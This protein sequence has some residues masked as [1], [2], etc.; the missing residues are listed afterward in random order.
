MID[1]LDV[2]KF[3]LLHGRY[4][5][6]EEGIFLLELFEFIFIQL[7]DIDHF[8]LRLLLS[9]GWHLHDA[10]DIRVAIHCHIVI[11]L[12]VIAMDIV[13]VCQKTMVNCLLIYS[14][15]SAAARELN[16]LFKL[17][18]APHHPPLFL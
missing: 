16:R 9:N 13:F 17:Y 6:V 3:C 11:V 4:G 8:W 15:I 12:F 1:R 10:D 2:G 5:V 7:F 18:D 14:N